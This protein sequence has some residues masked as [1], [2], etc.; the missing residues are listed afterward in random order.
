VR[1]EAIGRQPL[2]ISFGFAFGEAAE[3][4]GFKLMAEG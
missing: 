2:A 4:G 3:P 1:E